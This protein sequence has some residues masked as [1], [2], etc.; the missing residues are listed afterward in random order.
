MYYLRV[1]RKPSY[2]RFHLLSCHSPELLQQSHTV[3]L[4]ALTPPILLIHPVQTSS[5]IKHSQQEQGHPPPF[6]RISRLL[7]PG[8]SW[9]SST[10]LLVR[11]TNNIPGN[12]MMQQHPRQNT[13]MQKENRAENIMS[14]NACSLELVLRWCR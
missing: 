9:V 13:M 7:F 5:V 1:C 4:L 8:H 11:A 3:S 12:T 10:A 6:K 2:H 14:Y